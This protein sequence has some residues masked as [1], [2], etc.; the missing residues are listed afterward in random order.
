VLPSL[1]SRTANLSALA[2]G[3]YAA[4]NADLDFFVARGDDGIAYLAFV[5]PDDPRPTATYPY[6][7]PG[8]FSDD[9]LSTKV[10][11]P[12]GL[13]SNESSHETVA[14]EPGI[15]RTLYLQDGAGEVYRITATLDAGATNVQIS[16]ARATC[17]AAG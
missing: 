11:V 10:S 15:A 13:H 4:G 12:V 5:A 3:D 14:L 16:V 6:T 9:T 17:P 1:A 8:F 2:L 7:K